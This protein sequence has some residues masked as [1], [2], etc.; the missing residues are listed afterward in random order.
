MI[1]N[2]QGMNED[3]MRREIESDLSLN[4]FV[5]AGAGAGKTTLIVRRI[6]NML[7]GDYEPSEIVAITFTNKAAEEL[8]GR[9]ISEVKAAGLTDKL[10]RLDE[11]N[12]STIHSFCNVL[13]KEQS[14]AAGLP[15]DL[16]LI[17][18]EEERKFKKGYLN[19]YLRTLSKADWDQIEK[20]K[21]VNEDRRQIRNY[22][23]ELFMSVCDLASEVKTVFPR[24]L[25][26]EAFEDALKRLIKG[27]K[28]SMIPGLSDK[29]ILAASS[30][31][32]PLKNTGDKKETFITVDDVVQAADGKLV[33]DKAKG[34]TDELKKGIN[35]DIDS[36]S[37]L[38]ASSG[39]FF[40]KTVPVRYDKKRIDEANK[41]LK[42]FIDDVFLPYKDLHDLSGSKTRD[43]A[44]NVIEL[45][46]S[47]AV[48]NGAR[49]ERHFRTLVSYAEKARAYYH[50]N[51]PKGIITN[52]KL[53][54]L[55]RDL[56]L[57]DNTAPLEYFQGRYRTFFVDEF[58]DTDSIQADFIYRLAGDLKDRKKLREG[59]LFVVGD[60]KQSIYRFR[61]AEP[62]VY[63]RIREEMEK[64]DNAR[65][66]EL[67][68]NFRSNKE[69]IEWV[70]DRFTKSDPYYHIVNTVPEGMGKYSYKPMNWINQTAS[71]SK[72][73]LLSG[74]Y[75]YDN[76]DNEMSRDGG[77][78]F[79][80]TVCDTDTDVNNLIKV[81]TELT[82]KEDDGTAKYE[83]TRYEKQGDGSYAP[84]ADG[85]KLSDFLIISPVTTQMD[86]YV[87]ALK[88]Y[89]IPV[90]L[91]GRESLVR[92]KALNV[93]TRIYKYLINPRNPFYRTGAAEAIRESA[94]WES[95][96][97]LARYTDGIL[98][99]LYADCRH[100]S[101]YGKAQYLESQ[102]SVIFDK[103]KDISA[104][105]ILA[106][107]TH[108]RQMLEDVNVNVTGTG[109][110][111]IEEMNS[112]I[113]SGLEHEM[114]LREIPEAVRFMNLHKAKG[115]EG[116]IVILLDRHGRKKSQP[117]SMRTGNEYYPGVKPFYGRGW[118]SISGNSKYTDKYEEDETS[119]FHRLEYVALTRAKQVAIFLDVISD[120][121]KYMRRLFAQCALRGGKKADNNYSYDIRESK[122]I[123]DTKAVCMPQ[124][125]TLKTVDYKIIDDDYPAA[126]EEKLMDPVSYIRINPSKLEKGSSPSK[127]KVRDEAVKAGAR[128]EDEYSKDLERPVGNLLGNALHNAMELI[129]DGLMQRRKGNV[130]YG[131]DTEE[132]VSYCSRRAV[133]NLA[134][135]CEEKGEFEDS[136]KYERFITACGKAYVSWLFDTSQG[137]SI[138]ERVETAYT[139]LPFSYSVDTEGRKEWHNGS[140]DLIFKN[141]DGSYTLIDYK[142]DND[143]LVSEDIMH[144]AFDE[145][146]SPQLN[147]YKNI[148]QKLFNVTP[149]RIQTGIISFS[150]KDENGSLLSDDAV[151][152]RYT[153]FE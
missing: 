123:F 149:D 56:I 117:V 84:Y 16:V 68:K 140:A 102:T 65:T 111:I 146:Y 143:Y 88:S 83:I 147:E 67:S 12:I 52:D 39:V 110:D 15:Q 87:M 106:A 59:A 60:P 91:D 74:V 41:E 64:L 138:I 92:D 105:D 33:S 130:L 100:M 37:G 18:D 115:L 107:R 112:Y 141:K 124:K 89:G 28:T 145:K 133:M 42:E 4:M 79:E 36:I 70:N 98:D 35:C 26:A 134:R 101:P 17:Q 75:R 7:K 31:L 95:E 118:S 78:T 99:C 132:L 22:I 82:S 44:G 103:D 21:D 126:R 153:L 2:S 20:D 30:C 128:R 113:E 80:Y 139:E 3:D 23:E 120:G 104:I 93:F 97:E 136:D 19:D 54:E 116:N 62:E 27:D 43:Q 77:K 48:E 11:M 63:F 94:N 29:I 1:M 53:L 151:R 51:R 81:I 114:S 47:E 10:Y 119:E 127:N 109:E 55:T 49:M 86:K 5:E 148:I 137:E 129:V 32:D 96:E 108:I 66:Y 152:I 57:G 8:R 122:Q 25:P 14:V 131:N 144:K 9:I 40:K 71:S 24:T 13:L 38:F 69:I 142:S 73:V 121:K 85:I 58:Q 76:P 61:G 34:I 125:P 45:S 150:Q 6:V 135:S 46:F 72:G 50:E 90:I